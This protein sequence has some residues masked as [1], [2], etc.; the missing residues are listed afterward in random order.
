[1]DVESKYIMVQNR[2]N[3][4]TV[5]EEVPSET[6]RNE[7]MQLG[8]RGRSSVWQTMTSYESGYYGWAVR[9][10]GDGS[11]RTGTGTGPS[12]RRLY[13]QTEDKHLGCYTK[14]L[15]IATSASK[16]TSEKDEF[17]SKAPGPIRVQDGSTRVR[18]GRVAEPLSTMRT[19]RVELP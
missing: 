4:R 3:T 6:G 9:S 16:S 19:M 10:G 1:M 7:S 11:K 8:G 12:Y 17:M 13:C 15:E 5:V 2:R 18:T 14:E